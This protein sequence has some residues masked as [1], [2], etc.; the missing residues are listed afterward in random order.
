MKLGKKIWLAIII[1]SLCGQIAWTVENML[2]NVFIQ[3]EFHATLNDIA[4]MVSLS[5]IAATITTLLMGALSDRVG[6]RK[7]F[8]CFGY[9]VWGLSIMSFSLLKVDI[10]H[11]TFFPAQ[12]SFISAIALGISLTIVFDCIMTFFGSTANDAAFNAW[13]TDVSDETNRGKIEGIN[14][15]MP[16][17]A[18]LVVF[19]C[20]ML[21][22][23][24]DNHWT[25]LF[26]G[27][28][29]LVLI[30]GVIGLFTIQ[31]KKI[32]VRKDEPYFKNIFYGLRPTV[33]KEN[34]KL[35]LVLLG[36]MIFC[37]SVQVF[38]PYL[39]LYF[40]NT[41]H[42]E[43][44]VI[45]FAPAIVLAALFTFFY[46]RLIDKCGFV[47]TLALSMIVYVVGLVILTIFSNIIL[48]F[49]GTL[50]MMMG[51]LS[52]TACFNATIRNHT[53]KEKV[54]LFQGIRIIVQV[55]I[56]M[57]IGPWIGSILSGNSGEGFVGVAGDDYTPSSLIFLGAL[58]VGLFVYLIIYIFN[59]KS[60]HA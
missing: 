53:P 51:Y 7:L 11:H 10:L 49:I 38:M 18:V 21:I 20:N 33:I 16:L 28:G 35:Y 31:D 8:I 60:K 26:L 40:S 1:F 50:F 13:M 22:E 57:L 15:A 44:Y 2:F 37:T 29:I 43:N 6:K 52:A 48:V 54:G 55:L 27:I 12:S 45:V 9:I 19:G 41:I 30:A 39:I 25:I 58:V 24:L 4:L 56:P 17:L 32:E 46:G 5:A 42:L 14:S 36:F 59:R 3:E 23:P 47:K 34:K